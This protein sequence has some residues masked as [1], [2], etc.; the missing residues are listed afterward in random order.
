MCDKLT[1]ISPSDGLETIKKAEASLKN[2]ILAKL[3]ESATMHGVKTAV[4]SRLWGLRSPENMLRLCIYFLWF[5]VL[6]SR[7]YAASSNECVPSPTLQAKLQ[8][9]PNANTLAEMGI[10]YAD[11][12]KYACA[13]EAYRNALQK[14]PNSAEFTY[15]LGLSLI[16]KGD[17]GGAVKPLQQSIAFNP[18]VLKP[19]LLL[20]TALEDL[21][22]GP[23]ARTE[24][25][26]ALK[27]DP[28]SEMAL[29]GASKNFLAARDFGSVVDLL[30]P[31]P[32]GENLTLDLAL[33]YEGVGNTEQAIDV[34]K[35]GLEATP[36]SSALTTELITDLFSQRR[37]HEAEELAK[38]LVQRSPQNVKA[39]ILYLHVLVLNDD[40]NE[41]RPLAKKLLS[42]APRNFD[43]LYLNGVL[44]NRSANY[45]AARIYLEKAVAL[46][47]N[48]Y[49]CRYNLGLA[50][51]NLNDPRRA[52]EQFEK[53]LTLGN[54]DPGLRFQYVK[55]LRTLGETELAEQQFKLY[56]QEQKAMADRTLAASKMGQ[57]D[58]E[59]NTDP[60]KAA[61]LYRDAVAA[62]PDF[63]P[64]Q[65]KLSVA[66]DRTGDV[67]GERIALQ[68]AVEIDPGMAIAHRQLGYLA[69]NDG[70]FAT[71]ETHFRKAVEAA[72]TFAD[73]WVSLAATLATESRHQEAEEAVKRAL[74]IDPHN[75][76]AI[77][78]QKDLANQAHP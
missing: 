16:R 51:A 71:A 33:A 24:W 70:D 44:E 38:Q 67:D 41:T 74:E 47:P 50:L 42:T 61:E 39:Q 43:V 29:D 56:Q 66:L 45:A 35:K 54:Q 25:L 65:Y 59:L 75:A 63:A 76:N 27:V 64:L 49:D 37:F 32:K 46:N 4:H 53:A 22:R 11:H 17:V 10:W 18:A 62:L 34:L 12:H 72:P 6:I 78:L 21:G 14:D 7:M 5:M 52:K 13:A 28:H 58:E 55:V 23:E 15:L 26:A 1:A 31:E 8:A 69:F 2:S 73:A 30:G 20:A 68:K 19:H 3:F 77:D 57:A 60:K 36:S 40:A 48:H 9:Q